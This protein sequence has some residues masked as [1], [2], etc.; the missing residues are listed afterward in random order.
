MPCCPAN[1]SPLYMFLSYCGSAVEHVQRVIVW[2][3][4]GAADRG[5]M[6][7]IGGSGGCPVAH[8][9]RW[10]QL[11]A[12]GDADVEAAAAAGRRCVKKPAARPRR[13]KNGN[14]KDSDEEDDSG[15]SAGAYLGRSEELEDIQ[16]RRP[17]ATWRSCGCC[18][19]GSSHLLRLRIGCRLWAWKKHTYHTALR[20]RVT[21][22]DAKGWFRCRTQSGMQ[23]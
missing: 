14:S 3:P 19:E 16:V 20:V 17:H 6:G 13:L 23:S 12:D 4:E 22:P 2:W 11:E 21:D 15:E 18:C 5:K 7:A 9:H 8:V 1:G 10:F